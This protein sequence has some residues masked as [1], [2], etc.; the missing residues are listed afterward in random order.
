VR[1]HFDQRR[2]HRQHTRVAVPRR[3]FGSCDPAAFGRPL[4]F[5]EKTREVAVPRRGFGSCDAAWE[6]VRRVGREHHPG[7]SPPKGIWVVRLN[8]APAAASVESIVALQSPEGDLGR[9]TCCSSVRPPSRRWPHRLQSP[10]GD[11]GRA[12]RC[13]RTRSFTSGSSTTLQ[14]PEGDLGRAT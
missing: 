4:R 2:D 10:E 8:A 5:R 13:A 14:S 1:R 3:G 6:Y 7:C 12:T 9:A 11:L